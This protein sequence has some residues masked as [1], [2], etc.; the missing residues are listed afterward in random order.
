MEVA[1]Q[2]TMKINMSYPKMNFDSG[3]IQLYSI[4]KYK[5]LA[6][7]HPTWKNMVKTWCIPT[8][9]P[10]LTVSL[11]FVPFDDPKQGLRGRTLW[12]IAVIVW[13]AFTV[14]WA[15]DTRFINII[16]NSQLTLVQRRCCIGGCSIVMSLIYSI[17]GTQVVY[18]V[19]FGTCLCSEQHNLMH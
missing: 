9:L 4:E 1:A 17:I 14:G 10:M 13:A 6:Q 19:P 12:T 16:R 18:P 2:K 3:L 5:D 7:F 8:L 15:I 11:T